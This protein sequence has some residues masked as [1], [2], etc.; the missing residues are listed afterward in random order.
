MLPDFMTDTIQKVAVQERQLSA[1][2][3][4][5]SAASQLYEAACMQGNAVEQ[6]RQRAILHE[7]TDLVLDARA[8]MHLLVNKANAEQ[9]AQRREG[10]EEA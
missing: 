3:L 1:L 6:D 7:V 5:V 8:H 4:Q 10:G 2:A 9:A